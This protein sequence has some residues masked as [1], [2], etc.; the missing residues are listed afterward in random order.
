M[1]DFFED[2]EP[3]A[4]VV[5]AF[6]R[7]ERFFTAPPIDRPHVR[8]DPAQRF[9][10]PHVKGI[11]VDAITCM[12]LAGESLTTVADEYGLTRADVLVACWHQGL[13]GTPRWRRMWRGWA[14]TA[15]EAMWDTRTVDYDAIPDPPVPAPGVR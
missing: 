14:K 7:G 12:L 15:G 11:S 3:V 2:D 4:K 13:Y 10:Q 8:T 5:A 1:T 9:G 6:E